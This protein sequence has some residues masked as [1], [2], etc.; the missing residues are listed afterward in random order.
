MTT[1]AFRK[2]LTVLAGDVTG[3]PLT[4]F[5]LLVSITDTDLKDD[6]RADGFDI[7]FTESDG[8]TVIPYDREFYDSSTGELIAW[9]LLDLSDITDNNF[10]MFYG[11]PNATDQQNPTAVWSARSITDVFHF[12][13]SSFPWLNSTGGNDFNVQTGTGLSVSLGGQI[14]TSASIDL[15]QTKFQ[16][17]SSPPVQ[18]TDFYFSFW[19]KLDTLTTNPG[20][21][22]QVFESSP[23]VGGASNISVITNSAP[24]AGFLLVFIDKPGTV[25]PIGDISDLQFHHV[26]LR[27]TSSSTTL[28]IFLDGTLVSSESLSFSFLVNFDPVACG[29]L[30]FGAVTA[31]LTTGRIDELQIAHNSS[32]SNGYVTTSF[33]NQTG[34][35]AGNFVKVGQQK[36][37][38]SNK[39]LILS[40]GPINNKASSIVNAV[41]GDSSL[42]IGDT[43]RLL[44]SGTGEG[45]TQADDILPRVGIVDVLGIQGYGV[46]VGGDFEGVYSDGVLNL[47]SNNLALGVVASFFGDGVRICTQGRCLALT[48]G[49]TS[50]NI[51]DNLTSSPNGLVIPIIGNRIIAIALQSASDVNNI[52]AVN[53]QRQGNVD[54]FTSGFE[55]IGGTT[56]NIIFNNGGQTGNLKYIQS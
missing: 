28:D 31:N 56:S 46:V 41:C 40:Q 51:G 33:D 5:P 48:D 37:T 10:F 4:D 52:I 12:N 45:F 39:Y 34:Q 20:S 36:N 14:D 47:N 18:T 25:N 22:L 16:M 24:E 50:I 27:Y 17:Q 29:G 32:F 15:D 55:K 38:F 49:T 54:P 7:F 2:D 43:V 6:A 26:A 53:I 42:L 21:F 8:T 11:N 9:V 19:V 23:E 13:Q 44:P 3:G 30:A 1:A 35:G